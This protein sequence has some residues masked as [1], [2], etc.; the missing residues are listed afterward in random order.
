GN[1]FS[2]CALDG[3][4]IFG[5]KLNLCRKD[6]SCTGEEFRL[7]TTEIKADRDLNAQLSSYTK[8]VECGN[9]Y[10]DC[11]QKECGTTF[12]KCLGKP[13]ADRAAKN[14]ETIAKNCMEQDSG[15][16]A[17]FGTAIGKLRETAEKEVKEDE[18]RMYKLRDDMRDQCQH[19]GAMF[20]ERSFDCVYTVNFF[21][22]DDQQTPKASRKAYAGNTFV[23]MQEWFGINVTTYKENAYRETRA[24]SAASSAM[25]GSGVGTAAGLISSGAIGR[26]LDTQKAKKDL[27]N[28]CKAQGGIMKNGECHSIKTAVE[29]VEQK[30]K[31]AKDKV[32]SSVEEAA[33]DTQRVSK[34]VDKG[35]AA[36]N[37]VALKPLEAAEQ[38]TG[39]VKD[40]VDNVSGMA[41][42]LG[43]GTKTLADNVVDVMGAVKGNTSALS[44]QRDIIKEQNKQG[45][46][47]TTSDGQLK[48]TNIGLDVNPVNAADKLQGLSSMFGR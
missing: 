22:G 9:K 15:L 43:N 5:D 12:N 37:D 31:E 38:T 42:N 35:A 46:Q 3:D 11:M 19:L 20:D 4:T 33:D 34:A 47:I 14:C 39:Q 32:I 16:S 23:C 2:K 6:I 40:V 25:L 17:R 10:N 8:V 28:E 21:A 29:K 30:A 27:K 26:A 18:A 36:V 24:Q 44:I 48:P 45:A 41:G 7:F 13:F 1:D